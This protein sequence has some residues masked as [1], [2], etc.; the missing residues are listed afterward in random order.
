LPLSVVVPW[1]GERVSAVSPPKRSVKLCRTSGY[2]SAS[3][4]WPLLSFRGRNISTR[5][6]ASG[7]LRTA[8]F[9]T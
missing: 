5:C 3:N 6:I 2:L 7:S 1:A 9:Q 4:D 8:T